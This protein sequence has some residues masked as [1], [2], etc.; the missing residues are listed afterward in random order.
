MSACEFRQQR[1]NNPRMAEARMRP[2]ELAAGDR[3]ATNPAV[4]AG[5]LTMA[6]PAK[7]AQ[8]E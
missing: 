6:E 4:L 3:A 8:G 5:Q 2:A 1:E 7:G